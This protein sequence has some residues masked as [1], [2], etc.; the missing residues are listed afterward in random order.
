MR[1]GLTPPRN[2]RQPLAFPE[3]PGEFVAVH[4]RPPWH[5]ALPCVLYS[6]AQVLGEVPPVRLRRATAAPCLPSAVRVL[7]ARC[8]IVFLFA[9]DRWAF[10][11]M[12]LAHSPLAVPRR[13]GPGRRGRTLMTGRPA[14]S[15]RPPRSGHTCRRCPRWRAK[16]RPGWSRL[17]ARFLTFSGKPCGSGAGIPRSLPSPPGEV[18]SPSGLM[19]H[20]VQPRGRADGQAARQEATQRSAAPSVAAGHREKPT[21]RGPFFRPVKRFCRSQHFS[22]PGRPVDGS[23]S[24]TGRQLATR[25]VPLFSAPLPPVGRCNHH[26]DEAGCEQSLRRRTPG[27]PGPVCTEAGGRP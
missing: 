15:R 9:A 12:G 5:V 22:P 27:L 16:S 13:S 7:D 10:C 21:Y 3:L 17:S 19:D 20:D 25:Y 23:V 1:A 4:L 6:S 26:D 2:L 11:L 24:T 18:L 14:R 8:E